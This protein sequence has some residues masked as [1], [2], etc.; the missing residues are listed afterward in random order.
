M[1]A[2]A[3]AFVADP[4]IL[5]LDEATGAVDTRTEQAVQDAMA[6]IM[7]NRTGIIIAHRLSTIRDADRIVVLDNGEIVEQGT[8]DELLQQKG[9]YY[10]LYNT[11]YAGEAT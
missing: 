11:Q 2:I 10:D 9:K 1:L 5:I 6:R 8:H 3:R 4:D 7:Q